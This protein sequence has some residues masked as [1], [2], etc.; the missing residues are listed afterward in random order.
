VTARERVIASL[1]H[2]QPDATPYHVTFTEPAREA[3]AAW[4]GDGDFE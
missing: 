3:M 4:Y 1:D 2:R